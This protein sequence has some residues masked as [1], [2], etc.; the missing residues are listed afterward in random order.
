MNQKKKWMHRAENGVG[1]LL[2]RQDPLLCLISAQ[3]PS[4]DIEPQTE[5]I[6][7]PAMVG[8]TG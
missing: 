7:F 3:V 5:H 1:I 2:C 6:N 8:A 4:E